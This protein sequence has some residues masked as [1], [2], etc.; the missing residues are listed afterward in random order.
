MAI[1][2]LQRTLV[3][4]DFCR[5]LFKPFSTDT[6]LLRSRIPFSTRFR[7]HV[8]MVLDLPS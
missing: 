8:L 2:G 3:F 7:Q 4:L 6:F 1:L 5:R